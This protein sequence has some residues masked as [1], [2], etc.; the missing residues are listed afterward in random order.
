MELHRLHH[1]CVL[2][3][4]K[5]SLIPQF[6]KIHGIW[7]EEEDASWIPQIPWIPRILGIWWGWGTIL[8]P[9]KGIDVKP[10]SS[11]NFEIGRG[12]PLN[13]YKHLSPKLT[14]NLT[15]RNRARQKLGTPQYISPN[16]NKQTIPFTL[17]H[18]LTCREYSPNLNREGSDS[19]VN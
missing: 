12:L 2:G 15:K 16:A 6:P 8:N 19:C 11:R 1:Q 13:L 17:S 4:T 9:S 5:E 10:F 14:P 3:G 18:K 7:G